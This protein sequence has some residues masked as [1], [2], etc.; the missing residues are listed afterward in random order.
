LYITAAV[1]LHVTLQHHCQCHNYT[2]QSEVHSIYKSTSHTRNVYTAA[3]SL[4]V[5]VTPL[6]SMGVSMKQALS[7]VESAGDKFCIATPA[8]VD[9]IAAA[10][11]VKCNK[12]Q[13]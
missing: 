1:L 2:A 4:A 10:T 9:L 3:V 7:S 5:V 12:A 13:S 6:N 11:C 8:S